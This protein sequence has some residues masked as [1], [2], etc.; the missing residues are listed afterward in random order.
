MSTLKRALAKVGHKLDN[1]FD[2]IW[3][4]WHSRL[5]R[6]GTALMSLYRG[7]GTA[8][9]LYLQGRVLKDKHIAL[10]TDEDSTWD[11]IVA[12]YKRFNSAEIGGAR[13]SAQVGDAVQEV[14]TD[15]EGYFD[16][17]L[18]PTSLPA[19][20]V[21]HSVKVELLDVPGG[22]KELQLD[23]AGEVDVSLNGVPTEGVGTVLVPNDDAQFGVISDIDDTIVRTQATSLLKM[24]KIT[25][26]NNARTRLP[27]EGVA[28]FYQALQLGASGAIFNPI[29]YVS[30]SPWNLYDLLTDFMD[31]HGIPAGPLFLQD[32]GLDRDKF[33]SADH[34]EH[35]ITRIERLLN[36]YPQLPFILIGDSGQA[37]PEIYSTIL[38]KHP[39]RILAIYIRD[40]QPGKALAERDRDVQTL[41]EKA[42]KAH[43]DLLL[44]PDTLAAADHA[45]AHGWITEEALGLVR[46]DQKL[47]AAAEPRPEA[48]AE[49]IAE[50]AVSEVE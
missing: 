2:R 7:Y 39:D 29:F 16:L 43:V 30:S 41:V 48:A 36:L 3:A 46:A 35:K 18:K 28:A 11:N 49:Q 20:D 50:R 34:E 47:D 40:V 37:D 32:Y 6:N 44:V 8:E 24:V 10:S 21:W 33:I 4:R 42:R 45:L 23:E 19:G 5:S 31:V 26:F 14:L 38:E 13:V 12:T 17:A 9:V 27:F 25:F 1:R 22:A 15:N